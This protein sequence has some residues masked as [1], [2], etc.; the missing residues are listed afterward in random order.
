MNYLDYFKKRVLHY[1]KEFGLTDYE[2]WFSTEKTEEENRAKVTW[3]ES[4]KQAN[5][6]TGRSWLRSGPSRAEIDIVAF[7]E[8]M[9]LLLC[10]LKS[11]AGDAGIW[12]EKYLDE[13]VHR[14]IRRIE[15]FMFGVGHP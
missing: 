6:I 8:V 9:E 15:N 13:Q 11:C 3:N 12:T 5:F 2:V 4:A 10:K 7:H 14:V 1:V